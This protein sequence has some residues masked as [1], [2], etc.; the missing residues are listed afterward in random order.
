MSSNRTTSSK[1][2]GDLH[3]SVVATKDNLSP[4]RHTLQQWLADQGIARARAND[5]VLCACE[6]LTNVVRHAYVD[7]AT[8]GTMDLTA[9]RTPTGTIVIEVTD[10]GQWL[11]P[12]SDAGIGG[13]GVP[14][15]RQLADNLVIEHDPSTR[16][17]A[18]YSTAR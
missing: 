17:V 9:R 5:M 16:V 18:R 6:A 13:M 10:T 11:P 1:V 14:I 15:M 7:R 4:V 12:R 8:P 2:V 3:V